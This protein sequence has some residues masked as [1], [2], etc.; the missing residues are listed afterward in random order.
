MWRY[1]NELGL[2]A[3]AGRRSAAVVPLATGASNTCQGFRNAPE[4]GRLTDSRGKS[5]N[6]AGRNSVRLTPFT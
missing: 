2:A 1:A 4:S 5:R 6:C 3:P